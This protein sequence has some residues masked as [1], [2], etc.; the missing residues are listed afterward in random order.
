MKVDIK[1]T[2]EMRGLIFKKKDFVVTVTVQFTEEEK[3]AIEMTKIGN[4]VLVERPPRAGVKD[5]KGL[6]D[7][8][9]LRVRQLLNGAPDKYEFERIDDAN[10][11]QHQLPEALKSLKALI[12]DY[13]EA[14]ANQSFEL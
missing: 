14:P 11:Y 7:V 2:E 4:Y 12:E 5:G 1:R 10:R 3:K 9:H 8:F 6:E 13:V